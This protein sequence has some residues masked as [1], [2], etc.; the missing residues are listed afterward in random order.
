MNIFRKIYYNFLTKKI[1]KKNVHYERGKYEDRN[2]LEAIIFP[3]ILAHK[4][5][6]T[7][8]DIGREDYQKFYNDFFKRRI[9]WTMDNDPEREKYGAPGKHITDYASNLKKHFKNNYF[10]FILMNGVLGWGLNSDEAINKAFNAIYKVLKPDGIFVLGW[11]DSPMD[12][13]KIEGLNK[14]KKYE[15]KPLG[16]SYFKCENGNHQ[17]GFYVKQS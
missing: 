8:L 2:V 5:P 1:I 17:Y 13:D 11:N 15:F 10:D 6:K 12:L 7:I 16:G 4:N 14:L 9:L 3:Y